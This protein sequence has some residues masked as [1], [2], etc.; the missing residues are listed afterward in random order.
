MRGIAVFIAFAVCSICVADTAAQTGAVIVH[1]DTLEPSD[2]ATTSSSLTGSG[3]TVTFSQAVPDDLADQ[4]VV[5]LF[6]PD[7]L[8]E[9]EQAR[10]LAFHAR[11]GWLV[12]GAEYARDDEVGSLETFQTLLTALGN[13][14]SFARSGPDVRR[15]TA[16]NS[17]VDH[18]LSD[19]VT[20]H[21]FSRSERVTG[22]DDIIYDGLVQYADRVVAAGDTSFFTEECGPADYDNGEL[23]AS[24]WTATQT[25]V[26]LD[27]VGNDEDVC[28]FDEDPFQLDTDGDL[29]GDECDDDDDNDGVPDAADLCPQHADPENTDGDDD[30][31]GDLC[32]L[33]PSV[34]DPDQAD[35]DFDRVGDLC[36]GDRDGDGAPNDQD[37]CPDDTEGVRSEFTNSDGLM[38]NGTA[39]PPGN[40]NEFAIL[41]ISSSNRGTT[42]FT[43]PVVVGEADSWAARFAFGIAD[44]EGPSDGLGFILHAHPDGASAVGGTYG[45]DGLTPSVAVALNSRDSEVELIR[46]GNTAQPLATADIGFALPDDEIATRYAWVLYDGPTR[47]LEVYVSAFEDRPDNP[48]LTH[49]LDVYEALGTEFYVG[50]GSSNPNTTSIAVATVSSID[51]RT[52]RSIDTDVDGLGDACDVC[53]AIADPE[54]ADAD[55]DGVGDACDEDLDN[56]GV[57]NDEDNCPTVANPD[58]TNTDANPDGG[59]ACDGDDD[60]DG[61]DDGQDLC[62]LLGTRPRSTLTTTG[63]AMLATIARTARTRTR[64]TETAMAS[65]TSVTSAR[66]TSTPTRRTRTRT[67]WET[68]AT[69]ARSCPTRSRWTRIATAAATVATMTT[70]TTASSTPRTT[71]TCSP[72]ELADSTT[73][74]A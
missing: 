55:G 4:A 17:R 67:A 48:T 5:L 14:M 15:C 54:Q 73:R 56:D 12:L 19:N 69:R 24:I 64:R 58:Q 32:D 20:T 22:G 42:F 61:R 53:P 40:G 30:G 47:R 8:S 23:V 50:A 52:S 70:T 45:V 63:S 10:L 36:D 57:V 2:F 34:A 7:G 62:P 72:A 11:G 39:R 27:G 6:L 71:A 38:F 28:P 3:A 1:G 9:A 66:R 35:S 65:V 59:D 68:P 37:S 43:D 26:D 49:V 46:D 41:T 44:I 18:P 31:V 21:V 25:D 13:P 16:S 74:R 60:D 29:A 33:C 51:F